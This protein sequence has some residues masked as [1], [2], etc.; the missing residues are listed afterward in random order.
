M[1][2]IKIAIATL[3]CKLNQYESDS[4]ISQ[5]QK[6]GYEI[7]SFNESADVYIVNTCTVTNK[8]DAKSRNI[9]NRVNRTNPSG[10][11]FVTG[12]Y[13]ETDREF[14]EQID[15]VDYVIGNEKKSQIYQIVSNVLINDT[16]DISCIDN[17][18]FNYEIAESTFH[19]RSF[20]KI[21]DG[22]NEMCSYCKIPLARGS[23]ESRP[24]NDILDNIQKLISIG[25]KE[26][27]LTGINIGDYSYENNNLDNL[28]D[29]ILQINQDFRIHLSSLEPKKITPH[30][31]KLLSDP[32]IC[33][34]IH[35]PL[36]SGSDSIL[37]QMARHYSRE[38]YYNIVNHIRNQH[39]FINITTDVMVGFPGETE[40][41]FLDTYNLINDLKITHSHTFKYSPRNGTPASNLR[42][43]VPEII[44]S[45]RS[46]QI[47]LLSENLTYEYHKTILGKEDQ[48]LIEK[49]LDEDTCIGYGKYYTR[50]HLKHNN[51]SIG[52]FQNVILTQANP[53]EILCKSL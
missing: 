6:N 49:N 10:K 52:Q 34:H 40:K 11:L 44:K 38:D 5:F 1:D 39:P 3:G 36:Q 43:Q 27:I 48:L 2:K 17:N 12:C 24:V 45:E 30:I 29:K 51:I 8:S 35:I 31:I 47:R 13:A 53:K 50:L 22:C 19:T 14:L 41:D 4:L 46:Q 7:V 20:L 42:D 18:R 37:N 9:M 21:Q 26:I 15:G 16:F 32:K 25:F 28:L 33:H 23:A